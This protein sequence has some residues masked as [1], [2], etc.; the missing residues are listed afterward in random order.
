MLFKNETICMVVGI[1]GIIYFVITLVGF[2]YCKIRN[3]TCCHE[4]HQE[5]SNEFK[6]EREEGIRES[7]VCGELDP[8]LQRYGKNPTHDSN[9]RAKES[10]EQGEPKYDYAVTGEISRCTGN[11]SQKSQKE[12]IDHKKKNTSKNET[13][14][15][16]KADEPAVIEDTEFKRKKKANANK[17]IKRTCLKS[18]TV[19]YENEVDTPVNKANDDTEN[20]SVSDTSYVQMRKT[21]S[22]SNQYENEGNKIS[23]NEHESNVY[24]SVH[25]LSKKMMTVVDIDIEANNDECMATSDKGISDNMSHKKLNTDRD[26]LQ[27]SNTNY[28]ENREREHGERLGKRDS[29]SNRESQGSGQSNES[30]KSDESEESNDSNNS[31]STDISVRSDNTD[32]SV[33][34]DN[35]PRESAPSTNPSQDSSATYINVYAK[36]IQI[37]PSTIVHMH[38][39]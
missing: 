14:T 36:H 4:T 1:A 37:G 18:G 25:G 2:I 20:E 29:Y 12:S 32:I 30:R 34:S 11:E 35:S 21:D 28:I 27:T 31:R 10:D 33:R 23:S 6:I 39:D 22:A 3:I 24:E 17:P 13:E 38:T 19:H 26:N 15:N 8:T 5:S 9:L 16:K 7:G